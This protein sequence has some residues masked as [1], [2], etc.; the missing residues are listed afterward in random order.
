MSFGLVLVR[1]RRGSTVSGEE[2]MASTK[3][4]AIIP[5]LLCRIL[6]LTTSTSVVLGQDLDK[7]EPVSNNASFRSLRINNC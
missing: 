7:Y 1:A 4:R 3:L 5:V 6:F 2:P